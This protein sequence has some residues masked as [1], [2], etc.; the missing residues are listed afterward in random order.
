MRA[1]RFPLEVPLR[2]RTVGDSSWRTGTTANISRSGVLFQ[3]DDLLGTDTELEMR[4]QLSHAQVAPASADLVCQARVVRAQP[5]G[6]AVPM[7]AAA[8]LRSRLERAQD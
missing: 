2:Y 6:N 1:Y 5:S 4:I 7:L 8:F 3:A